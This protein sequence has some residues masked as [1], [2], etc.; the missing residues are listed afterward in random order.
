MLLVNLLVILIVI[1][2]LLW[3]IKA[4]PIDGTIKSIITVVAVVVAVFFV[5][6][7]FG[8]LGHGRILIR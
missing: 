5:L 6:Q 3:A 4:L 8:L 1:G 2:V 7:A